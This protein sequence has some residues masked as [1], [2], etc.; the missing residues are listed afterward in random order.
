[1]GQEGDAEKD[2]H[3]HHVV[4]EDSGNFGKA[5]DLRNS[6]TKGEDESNLLV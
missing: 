3:Y 4:M 2:D 1:M 6:I 5:N